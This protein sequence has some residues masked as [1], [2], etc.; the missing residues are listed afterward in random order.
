MY[1]CTVWLKHNEIELFYEKA[2]K[3]DMKELARRDRFLEQIKREGSFRTDGADLVAEIPDI[4]IDTLM[5]PRNAAD[6]ANTYVIGKNPPRFFSLGTIKSSME[7][8]S[9]YAIQPSLNIA[10]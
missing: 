4:D 9:S 3:P 1:G 8:H 6:E 2:R 10:A 5:K 7:Q